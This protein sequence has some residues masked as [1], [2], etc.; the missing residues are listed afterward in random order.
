MSIKGNLAKIK[1]QC[2]RTKFLVTILKPVR[3]PCGTVGD[4]VIFEWLWG[5][6]H[7]HFHI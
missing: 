3:K 7:G 2:I 6:V 1:M 5:N 4:T